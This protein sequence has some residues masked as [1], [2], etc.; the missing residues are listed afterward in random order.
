MGPDTEPVVGGRVVPAE[1][2]D[3]SGFTIEFVNAEVS[4]AWR[5]G[6]LGLAPNGGFMTTLWAEKGR[7]NVFLIELCDASGTRRPTAPDRFP[8][9]PAV[10]ATD[11]P[12]IHSLSVALANNE[13]ERFVDKGT[14]LPARGMR[15]LRTAFE[16]RQGQ[17]GDVIRIPV[18]EGENKRAD[19]NRHIGMLEVRAEQV[20]RSIPAGSE[21]EVTIIID[22]SRLV[23]AKAYIPILDEE[24]EVLLHLGSEKGPDPAN[25]R[26]EA[27]REKAR[28]DKV[29]QEAQQTGDAPAQQALE[30]I[31]RERMVHDVESQLDAAGVDPDAAD[32]CEKR[33]LDLRVA[34]DEVEDCLEWPSLV[35][36]AKRVMAEGNRIVNEQGDHNDRRDFQKVEAEAKSALDSR[37]PDLLRQRVEA[38][39]ALVLRLL[40]RK[41]IL[42]V[43]FF[44]QLRDM[45]PQMRDQVEADQLISR[46]L[47]AMNRQDIEGLRAINR[48]LA[49]LLPSPPPPPDIS[50]VIR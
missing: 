45:K 39:R 15:F 21:V 14:P 33:L 44:Q 23:R 20:K 17:A 32:K 30:R 49:A 24:F 8:Y 40:D 13:V 25:L 47:Q 42:Q 43:I 2:Q 3:L 10:V 46:G 12:L 11:L 6:K 48:Q 38:I 22:E 28:L 7:T 18:V 35:A 27:E 9:T 1:G 37:D 50:T 19:R 26:R 5:S 31:D 29:R 16:V 36:E 4:P 41:G 34:V